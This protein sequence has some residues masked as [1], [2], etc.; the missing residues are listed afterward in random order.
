MCLDSSEPPPQL[1]PNNW[2]TQKYFPL[3][4]QTPPQ[5]AR[6][7]NPIFVGIFW[8]MIFLPVKAGFVY[9]T[10]FI[11]ANQKQQWC[12]AVIY[13]QENILKLSPS[14]TGAWW[15]FAAAEVKKMDIS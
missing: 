13:V 15:P 8:W 2:R 7:Q 9:S 5:T 6:H 1:F 4:R 14:P 10:G 11:L 3:W 12:F